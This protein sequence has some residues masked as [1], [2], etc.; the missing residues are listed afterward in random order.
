MSSTCEHCVR[1]CMYCERSHLEELMPGHP[2]DY[3]QRDLSDG[4][5]VES[6]GEEEGSGDEEEGD[7]EEGDEEEGDEE[8]EE[9]EEGGE[10][11]GKNEGQGQGDE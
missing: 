2:E 10:D 8:D 6:D 4:E 11:D 1:K 3:P 9:D 7:E 5:S